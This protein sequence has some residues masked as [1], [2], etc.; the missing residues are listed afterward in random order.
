MGEHAEVASLGGGP[1]E[2]LRRMIPGRHS[3]E[4]CMVADTGRSSDRAKMCGLGVRRAVAMWKPGSQDEETPKPHRD[5]AQR[6]QNCED[7]PRSCDD[8]RSGFDLTS[9]CLSGAA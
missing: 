5:Y 9:P 8:S 6:V 2:P 3:A 1:H 7:R 4:R